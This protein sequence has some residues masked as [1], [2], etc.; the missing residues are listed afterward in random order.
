MWACFWERQLL[1]SR[2]ILLL[3]SFLFPELIKF[4]FFFL[5]T[6]L[7]H[8]LLVK[9]G[10][11]N[12]AHFQ[13]IRKGCLV[14]VIPKGEPA[15]FIIVRFNNQ[16]QRRGLRWNRNFHLETSARLASFV[17]SPSASPGCLPFHGRVILSPSMAAPV[18]WHS[19]PVGGDI[20][21]R[22]NQKQKELSTQK[23]DSQISG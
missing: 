1:I 20:W 2:W 18:E 4:Y 5:R 17:I 6:L 23:H 21:S 13:I 12:R 15:G 9:R 14:P 8:F 22:P 3:L 10:L 7:W 16:S 19:L 11:V